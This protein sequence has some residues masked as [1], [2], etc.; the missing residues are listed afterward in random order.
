MTARQHLEKQV[1][2][3]KERFKDH[4]AV[5][6]H[7]PNRNPRCTALNPDVIV[8]QKLGTC[9][10]GIRFV[11]SGTYLCCI[12]DL[13]DSVLQWSEIITPQFLATCDFHYWFGK[14]RAWPGENGWRQWE[15]PVADRW[16]LEQSQDFQSEGRAAPAW[17][18]CLSIADGDM[19]RF[20]AIAAEVYDETGDAEL[21]GKIHA[22]GLVPDCQAIAQWVGL[23]MALHKLGIRK[24]AP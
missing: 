7:D 1:R 9:I 3:W 11:L 10:D 21:A 24:E 16:A 8:W 15:N 18:G 2:V 14:K 19:D 23:Q 12:G 5:I 20:I 22:A 13:G 6:E 17:V 4:D